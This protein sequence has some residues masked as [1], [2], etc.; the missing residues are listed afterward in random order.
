MLVPVIL[1]GGAGSRLWPLSREAT[2]K[3]FMMLADGETLL[4]KT[5]A[6]ALQLPQVGGVV[7]VTHK[8]YQF[9]VRTEL[10]KLGEDK[11]QHVLLEPVSRNTAA[12]I[13]MAAFA[14]QQQYGNMAVMLVMP[15]DH[16][17]DDMAAF[18]AAVQSALP[19]C[20]LGKLVTFGLVPERPETGF[21]Y[22]QQGDAIAGT[23]GFEVQR[24]VEKPD[25]DTAQQYLND[26]GYLWNAGIFA[27]R[28]QDILTALKQYTPKLFESAEACWQVAKPGAIITFDEILFKDI[29]S[30]SIDYAVMEQAQNVA[31]IPARFA[32]ND[33]GSWS[34]LGDLTAPDAQGNRVQGEA[35]LHDVTNT[36][37]HSTSGWWRRWG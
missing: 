36:Y 20:A 19:L 24:F 5:Y 23:G 15:S 7:T 1:C 13:A 34:S 9:L 14:V 21:G 27:W 11:P 31:T 10:K 35:L 28:V 16:M 6:R 30:I 18:G 3:P 22:I 37:I 4:Q 17:I 8:D 29:P 25:L 33:I 32:W 12:A 2:P 26:G